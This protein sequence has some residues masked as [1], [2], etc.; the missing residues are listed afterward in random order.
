MLKKTIP[1]LSLSLLTSFSN[2][3]ANEKIEE[4]PIEMQPA[5]A[6]G[7]LHV[8]L[9]EIPL[10]D[11]SSSPVDHT[12]VI[13][14]LL[15]ADSVSENIIKTLVVIQDMKDAPSVD[16]KIDVALDFAQDVA[17][18]KMEKIDNVIENMSDDKHIK[19][20]N[21][22]TNLVEILLEDAKE[23]HPH[24]ENISKASEIVQDIQDILEA[25]SLADV[26]KGGVELVEDVKD[27]VIANESWFSKM[28]RRL[29]CYCC[30]SEQEAI[31]PSETKP[32][33][34]RAKETAAPTE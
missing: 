26:G 13:T 30:V 10:D 32:V 8:D 3:Q 5:R 19:R 15:S 23:K 27:L 29:G 12:A 28:K 31:E 25:K 2:L 6:V 9:V 4:L 11:S 24:N 21:E 34:E 33:S 20:A 7:D 17:P 16:E 18:Q 14:K 22:V 1:Y